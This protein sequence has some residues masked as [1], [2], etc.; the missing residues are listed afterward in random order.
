MEDGA[1]S[2][3]E[4]I[5]YHKML[6]A[7]KADLESRLHRLDEIAIEKA[8]DALDNLQLAT[9][10]DFAI[11]NLDRETSLLR[12]VRG[13]LGRISDG[14]YGMCLNCEEEINRKRL[15]AVPWAR[16]CLACQESA[17]RGQEEPVKP[18]AVRVLPH[19][20]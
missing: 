20:A 12:E 15:A 7:K 3:K 10:R 2:S 13:A 16:F 5:G 11:Q 6:E 18:G 17:D 14:T 4:L 1:V 8:A 9:E 19:A